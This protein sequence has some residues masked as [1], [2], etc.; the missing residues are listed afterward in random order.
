VWFR[1]LNDNSIQIWEAFHEVFMKQWAIRK[2]GRMLLNQLHEIKKKKTKIVNEF[3]D[4][5]KKLV[6]SIP[7]T[8]RPKD[9]ILL[10]YTNAFD[11][12]FGLMLR[13]K[14]PANAEVAQDC[15]VKIE[16]NMLSTKVDPLGS[17]RASA[18]KAKT[19]P[20]ALN[21][22]ELAQDPITTLNEKF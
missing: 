19:K 6:D 4:R 22:A 15:V 16:E 5:F 10:Q 18:S 12:H 20:R 14:F 3:G 11:G 13:D 7:K 1:G 9:A 2:D 21:S 17:P 8:I